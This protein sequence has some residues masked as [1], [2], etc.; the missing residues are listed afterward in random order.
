[1]SF[2]AS[3]LGITLSTATGIVDNLV[4]KELVVRGADSEDRRLVICALSSQGQEIIN[5]MWELGQLQMEKLLDGLSLEEL[6]KSHEIAE[7]LLH[8]VRSKVNPV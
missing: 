4:K 1:M 5:R 7:I 3:S 2:I 6:G 8:N